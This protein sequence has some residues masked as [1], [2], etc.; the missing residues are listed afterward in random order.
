MNPLKKGQLR[1]AGPV[2]VGVWA[3]PAPPHIP[4]LAPRGYFFS[5]LTH[6]NSERDRLCNQ[7]SCRQG[8]GNLI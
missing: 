2:Y 3:A 5:A 1:E 7:H 4:L 8:P 6:E